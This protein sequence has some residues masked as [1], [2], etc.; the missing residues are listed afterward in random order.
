LS[1]DGSRVFA[2]ALLSREA[3]ILTPP[4]P[5]TPYYKQQGPGL[6]G[7]VA[8][9]AIFTVS[10]KD[11]AFTPQVDDIGLTGYYGGSAYGYTNA[12]SD[13]G[14]PQTSYAVTGVYGSTVLQGPSVA[15]VDGLGDWL[16]VVNKESSNVAIISVGRRQARPAEQNSYSSYYGN[17]LPSV[18][19]TASVGAGADGIAILGDNRTAFVYSQF[20][21]KVQRLKIDGSALSVTSSTAI[22][23]DTLDP[24]QARGRK[25]FHD[26]NNRAISAIEASVACSSCHLEGR[27]DSHTWNFPDG[28]RQTP[29]LAGRGM[30]D[31]A[32]YHWSGEFSTLRDFLSHTITSRMG[33]TGLGDYEA[34]ELNAFVGRMKGPENPY[35]TDEPS[36]AVARGAAAFQK[37]QCNSCHAGQWLTNGANA[38]VGTLVTTGYNPDNGVVM[39]GINVPSLKGLARSAPYLH[40]GSA[41]TLKERLT[42]NP[43]DRHGITSILSPQELDDL[44]VFLRTL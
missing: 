42:R 7:S 13:P 40:D 28:P 1:P 11:G 26:A 27:D 17:E 21:H 41:A 29:T 44:V 35:V 32:P 15:L 16:Y 25:L 12:S 6:A 38:D 23:T 31:T 24:A 43:G 8:T 14:Y 19:A 20:D 5:I 4:S 10:T 22:A 3:P 34:N 33:G 2:T 9:P 37:A 30:L 36:P 39:N 18:Y